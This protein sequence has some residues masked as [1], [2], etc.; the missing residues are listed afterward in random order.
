MEKLAQLIR[1]G[2][3]LRPQAHGRL[4]DRINGEL[5]SCAVGS[6]LEACGYKPNV[7]LDVMATAR[8]RLQACGIKTEAR[9]K[10]GDYA[11]WDVISAIIDMNDIQDMAREEIADEVESWPEDD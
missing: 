7:R 11:G 8:K 1:D 3:K 2:S 4:F 5:H 9:V 10:V 6:A